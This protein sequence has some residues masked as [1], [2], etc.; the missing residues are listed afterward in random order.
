MS[1]EYTVSNAV[2]RQTFPSTEE[3]PAPT[4]QPPG[5]DAPPGT[6]S[7]E[8]GVAATDHAGRGPGVHKMPITALRGSF[9]P[10]LGGENKAH[11]ELLAE[12]DAPLPPI[13]V[14]KQ[15]LRVVDGMHRLLAASLKGQETIDVI[16]YDGSESDLFLRAVKENVEHG[17]PL[18]RT[19]RRV[20]A[21]RIVMT[22][23]HMSD[24]AIGQL[25][26]LAA[27]TIASIRGRSTNRP[28]QS[29][30]RVGRDGRVRPLD[31]SQ[32]RMRAAEL[33]SS[34]ERH[35]LRYIAR[36]TG[37]SPA[38]VLDVRKRL[39][40]GDPPVPDQ[41][42][43]AK[44]AEPEAPVAEDRAAD[45]DAEAETETIDPTD[46]LPKLLR[47]PSVRHSEQGRTLL[48][49]LQ[50]TAMLE[51]QRTDM[52][53][54]VPPHWIGVLAEVA[55]HYSTIWEKLGGELDFRSRV[56]DPSA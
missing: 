21:E 36:T 6:A 44:N 37:I 52:I 35:S 11:I 15:T 47:D 38:T 10:R 41:Y 31:S 45:R 27:R 17:L 9:S 42:A 23:P 48:R 2:D 51:M 34:D 1:I 32:A 19:E 24:R 14:H 29:E 7:G 12:T 28:A 16:F 55:R 53:E 50:A 40:R 4:G 39:E 18:T 43:T 20:A 22:H 13:L 8:S 25:T 26:G 49:L 30:V 3:E 54:A 5:G 33:L 46:V 56:V